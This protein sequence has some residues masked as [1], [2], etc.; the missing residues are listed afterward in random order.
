MKQADTALSARHGA[1]AKR[2][3][4]ASGSWLLTSA[5]AGQREVQGA[6]GDEQGP[7]GQGADGVCTWVA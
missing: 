4:T 1:R 2:I 7:R 3:A 5:A 6:G